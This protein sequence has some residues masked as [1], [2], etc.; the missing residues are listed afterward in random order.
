MAD[1]LLELFSEEIPARMQLKAE[2]NLKRLMAEALKA[3]N[4]KFDKME[5]F[6]TPR[7][8]VLTVEGLP[9]A[10]VDIKGER[11]GP[12]IDA[13]EKAIEGFL[14]GSGVTREDCIE[15]TEKKGTFLVAKSEKKGQETS[16]LLAGILLEVIQKFPWPKSQKW[17]DGTLRW[18]RPL[19]SILCLFDGKIVNFDIDGVQ[20]GNGTHG[21]RF[22]APDA[23][24]VSSFVDYRAKLQNAYVMLDPSDR[25]DF[26]SKKANELAK[27][28]GLELV[29]DQALL[30][31]VAGLV[32]WP[33]PILG[34]FDESFM[35]I[36]FEAL[37]SELK[38]HQKYFALKDKSGNLAPYFI[39]TANI[40]GDIDLI[41]AGNERVLGARLSDAKFFWDQDLKTPLE[42]SA[43]KLKN[44]IFHEKLGTVADKIDRV[45]FLA[46]GLANVIPNCNPKHAKRAAKLS[47]ADLVTGM[48]GEFPDLQGLMGSYYAT[49]QG[50]APEVAQAIAEHYS[51]QGPNDKCPTAPTSV[52]VALADKIDSLI[53]FFTI[54]EKPTGSKDPFA[55]RRAAIGVIRLITENGLRLSLEKDLRA[56]GDLLKFFADR[57][58]VQQKEK[59]TRHD[60]IDAVFA[61]VGE[62]DLVRILGRV[63]ALQNFLGTDDGE[64]LVSGYKRAT[65]IVRIEEKKDG[66]SYDG[67]VDEA[68]LT[69]PQEKDLF[70]KLKDASPKVKASVEAGD[71]ENAMAEIATLRAPIDAFFEAVTVNADEFTVRENRLRILSKIRAS[72][73]AIAD[74]SCIE[75]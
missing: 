3:E 25:R 63:K 54:D 15:V 31:E 7:R 71:F 41:R 26:V 46:E 30:N 19:Q 33:V 49:A 13:P 34:K 44:I 66:L 74:F 21:H 62:D 6:S 40:E 28:E 5:S 27:A 10:Q 50:E 4:L 51:P 58:K 1:L 52:A 67:D 2:E 36:P 59:G 22:V 20:S 53:G 65:N 32:E 72:L 14:R 18:V 42:E 75:G 9:L 37:V 68:L 61:L 43:K 17:G 12:R 64:N 70:S 39:C 47:K 45:S 56:D 69:E 23:F 29:E 57:L 38:H 60:L 55:L 48:V 16:G 35:E 8:L 73:N 24:E 11:R